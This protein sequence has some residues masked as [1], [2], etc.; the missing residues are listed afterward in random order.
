MGGITKDAFRGACAYRAQL[1]EERLKRLTGP[2]ATVI[3]YGRLPAPHD[4]LQGL[5]TLWAADDIRRGGPCPRFA[6]RI[7]WPVGA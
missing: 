5:L 4:P 3:E 7:V 1:N 6:W 2:F